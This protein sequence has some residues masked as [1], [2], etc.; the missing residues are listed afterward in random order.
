MTNAESAGWRIELTV[1]GASAHAYAEALESHAQ[2]VAMIDLPTVGLWRIEAFS[3]AEPQP[4]RL[5]ADLAVIAAALGE[6]APDFEV[7]ALPPTNWLAENRKRFPPLRH[8]RFF[9]HGSHHRKR[10][11]AGA[12]R[13]RIDAAIAFG[14]GEHATTRGCL[15][16]LDARARRRPPPRRMLDMGCGSGILSLGAARAWPTLKVRAADIDPIAVM[17]AR[18]NAVLNGLARQV[19]CAV[20][21]GYRSRFVEHGPR[22]DLITANVLARPLARMAKD[23]ARR[24]APG[25]L[26]VL[27]GLLAGQERLVLEAHRRRRLHLV[28]RILADGWVT[29]LLTR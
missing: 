24:L 17:V 6:A 11:P 18:E 29:L 25:G 27:S 19:R 28:R 5:T 26:L 7:R 21:E 16:A 13:L 14:S 20:S 9:I 15:M 2:A 8:G 10:P 1:P 3:E 4:A 23:A 22:F 12:W